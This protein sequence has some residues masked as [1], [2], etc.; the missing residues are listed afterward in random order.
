MKQLVGAAVLKRLL[1]DDDATVR[2]GAD[3]AHTLWPGDVLALSGDLGAGKT[4]LARGLLRALAGDRLLEVPSPTF[5][6]VQSYELRLPVHHLDL[7]RLSSPDE[8]EEL[9]LEDELQT[10]A[11][12]VEWPD[13][14]GARLPADAV[15]LELVQHGA[16]RMATITGRGAFFGRIVRSLA[17]RDFLEAAG[18]GKADRT[19]FPGDASAR[20]YETVSLQGEADR[21]LMN[22]PA[23]VP[24]PPVRGGRAYAEIAYSARDVSAF[25]AVDLALQ[26]AGLAVPEIHAQDLDGGFLLISHLGSEP[27]L[28]AGEPVPQ[29][30]EAAAELLAFI[31]GR[32]WPA[33]IGIGRSGRSHDVPPFDREALMI[34]VEL[35]LD[36][37]VP[38]ATGRQAGAALRA[39]FAQEW[40]RLIDRLE[41]AERSLVL[42]DFH[43][44]NI[45]WRDDR[46]GRDRLGLLD[47]QDALMGPAAYDVASLAMDARVTISEPLEKRT[48]AAYVAARRHDPAFDPVAFSEAYAIAAAQRNSKILGIFVRLDRRDGKPQYLRHLPRIRAYVGRALAHPSLAGLAA[49]YRRNGL[50]DEGDA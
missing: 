14:A 30:Y 35:L 48:V 42:R 41:T 23:L 34:E 49:L 5:T 4:T 21:I 31:H 2:L 12:L 9:G 8:L 40:N 7:Y 25:V 18:W 28:D 32:K 36:W 45:V 39:G 15:H 17:A 10:G 1:D 27:F 46:S 11:A 33:H 43:S 6:L 29:R 3:L 22:S 26:E 20:A 13:R 38:Y 16:G 44:P 50:L 24:G 19:P 47:F 37:Y